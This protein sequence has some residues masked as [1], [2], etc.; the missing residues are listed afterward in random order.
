MN[1]MKDKRD[2]G[3][4]LSIDCQVYDFEICFKKHIVLVEDSK[5]YLIWFQLIHFRVTL[6]NTDI[7]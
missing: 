5:L 2:K 1:V 3:V 7:G 6:L 4:Y